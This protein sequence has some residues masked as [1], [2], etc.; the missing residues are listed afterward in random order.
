MA[1][2]RKVTGIVAALIVVIISILLLYLSY[3]DIGNK[4]EAFVVI[5]L[6]AVLFALISYLMHAFISQVKVVTAFVWTYYAFGVASMVYGTAIIKFDVLY[7]ILVLLF[8]LVSIAFIYWRL[9]TMISDP[10]TK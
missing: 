3:I 9:S 10:G 7:L 4:E 6:I 2:S 5:G 1:S 8:V